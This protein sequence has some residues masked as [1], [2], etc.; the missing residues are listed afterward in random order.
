[1]MVQ[2]NS[3]AA[4]GGTNGESMQDDFL[5]HQP[6]LT[7]SRLCITAGAGQDSKLL[8]SDDLDMRSRSL[9]AGMPG[10]ASL[11]LVIP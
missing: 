2:T 4:L 9:S 11:S 7:C 6:E 1:M 8:W 3:T 10:A 5:A